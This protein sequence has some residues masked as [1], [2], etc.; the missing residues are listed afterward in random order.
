M[1]ATSKFHGAVTKHLGHLWWRL[2]AAAAVRSPAAAA[3]P[4]RVLGDWQTDNRTDQ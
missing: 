2:W 4:I 3:Q 1:G